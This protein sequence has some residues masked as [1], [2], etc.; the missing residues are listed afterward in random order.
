MKNRLWI[1]VLVTGFVLVVL[2]QSGTGAQSLP[3]EFAF[4]G[5]GSLNVQAFP[6]DC[7]NL[8]L[9][10]NTGDTCQCQSMAGNIS[11][12]KYAGHAYAFAFS[13]DLSRSVQNGNGNVCF[14]GTGTIKVTVSA[15]GSIHFNVSG[16]VCNYV[17]GTMIMNSGF[18]VAGFGSNSKA[19][20]AGVFGLAGSATENPVPVT[21]YLRGLGGMLGGAEFK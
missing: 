12:G 6:T 9:T 17:T 15:T 8:G 10:C 14:I 1:W 18:Q 16:P 19:T 11:N 21:F 20:G 4:G 7:I 5:Q 3:T 2:G 13:V